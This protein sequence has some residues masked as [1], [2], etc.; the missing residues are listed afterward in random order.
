M[1]D[2]VQGLNR[3]FRKEIGINLSNKREFN[4]KE[5]AL[6]KAIREFFLRDDVSRASPDVKTVIPDPENP[7][8]NSPV[9][10]RMSTL[11]TL[12]QKFVAECNDKCALGTFQHNVPAWIK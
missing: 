10:Y 2:G 3:K 9:Q 12:H 7:G 11:S 8:Q 1:Q 5:T 6:Q 4:S